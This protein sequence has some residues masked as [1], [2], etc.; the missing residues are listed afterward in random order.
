MHHLFLNLKPQVHASSLLP[1]EAEQCEHK[2]LTET[3]VKKGFCRC[4]FF[5]FEMFLNAS[6]VAVTSFKLTGSVETKR[7]LRRSSGRIPIGVLQR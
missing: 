1:L 3:Q 4:I 7:E 6:R 2:L 5:F